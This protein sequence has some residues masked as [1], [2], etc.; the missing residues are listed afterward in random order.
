M[1]CAPTR[2]RGE[3]GA[4]S[5][6]GRPKVGGDQAF[7]SKVVG[8]TWAAARAE[9]RVNSE[10]RRGRER[11]AQNR[12]TPEV[13]YATADLGVFGC[14]TREASSRTPNQQLAKSFSGVFDHHSAQFRD[15]K[16]PARQAAGH[17][18][19]WASHVDANAL[20]SALS[21]LEVSGCGISD[22]GGPSP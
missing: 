5:S 22:T 13:S 18:G 17:T 7:G 11:K 2:G 20:G 9:P 10:T 12:G 21:A 14:G 4:A 1:I 3:S 19:A 16:G 8:G 6:V 15:P